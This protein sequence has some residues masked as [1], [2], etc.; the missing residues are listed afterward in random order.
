MH[1]IILSPKFEKEF[2]KLPKYIQHRVRNIL[3]K[4]VY[5]LIG[6][7]LKGDLKGFYSVHFEKNKYRLIYYK[8]DNILQVLVVYIGKRTNR[9]YDDFRKI[10]NGLFCF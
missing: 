4:L 10:L 2:Y 6:D 9:F 3:D 5:R 8:E 7:P 1:E